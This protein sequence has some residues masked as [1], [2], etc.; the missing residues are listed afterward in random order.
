[1][2]AIKTLVSMFVCLVALSVTFGSE[3]RTTPFVKKIEGGVRVETAIQTT[4][5]SYVS[6]STGDTFTFFIVRKISS[7][8]QRIW[9]RTLSFQLPSGGFVLM[10]G[11]AETVDGLV[12]AGWGR[13]GGYYS[14]ESAVLVKLRR[15]GTTQWTK[16]FSV[17]PFIF[18]SVFAT[19]DGG[20][21][22]HASQ[23]NKTILLKFSSDHNVV[24]SK[25]FKSSC[26]GLLPAEPSFSQPVS[27]GLIFANSIVDPDSGEWSGLSVF[28]VNDS[29]QV[30]W[31]KLLKIDGF[32]LYAL[33]ADSKNG[34]VLAGKSS[35]SNTLTLIGLNANGEVH[36]KESYLLEVPSFDISSLKQTLDGGYVIAGT[37]FSPQTHGNR[38][39]LVLRIDAEKNL[40]FQ[41]IF[42]L[43]GTDEV[44][45]FIFA[46]AEGGFTLFGSSGKDMLILNVNSDGVVP[47][48]R[49]LHK[50]RA[51]RVPSPKII[52]KNLEIVSEDFSLSTAGT[53]EVNS[54]VS[55]N[56]SSN[57][58]L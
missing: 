13:L 34:V 35:D 47:G 21:M 44:A 38:A 36:W 24:L 8:G 2:D 26:C 7:S 15:N 6:I 56:R 9:E 27:D 30:I 18:D 25:S 55:K 39:G 42:G 23:F 12:L 19:A 41:K 57:A 14:D 50:L 20:F 53:I 28:K 32:G 33:G 46:T 3:V 40:V 37:R 5:G 29:G 22:I 10:N 16:T 52:R 54:E 43:A 51:K 49:F 4:D 48:C 17:P 58:C 45:D 1:M 31:K 11:I